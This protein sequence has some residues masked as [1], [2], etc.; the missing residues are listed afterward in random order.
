MPQ[1]AATAAVVARA[2]EVVPHAAKAFGAQPA[3]ERGS[4]TG[5][6]AVELTARD[7]VPTG[8]AVGRATRHHPCVRA[9]FGT[10]MPTA[11]TSQSSATVL[12]QG[13]DG[14]GGDTH[15]AGD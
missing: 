8:G 5:E 6:Q 7:P 3:R 15:T 4:G 1:R 2:Q 13:E 12:L 11:I 9:Q 14:F 10:G